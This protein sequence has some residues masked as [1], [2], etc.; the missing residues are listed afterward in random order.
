MKVGKV[1]SVTLAWLQKRNKRTKRK[2][3]S[4]TKEK[5]EG[6]GE[7]DVQVKLLCWGVVLECW[8]VKKNIEWA[9]ANK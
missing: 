3:E 1:V 2:S 7:R 5:R 6:R 8:V 4:D 9:A